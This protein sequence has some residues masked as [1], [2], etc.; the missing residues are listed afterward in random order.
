MLTADIPEEDFGGES[1]ESIVVDSNGVNE[2]GARTPGGGGGGMDDSR[3]ED[4]GGL[5]ETRAEEYDDDGVWMQRE[6]SADVRTGCSR[7]FGLV[8]DSQ[9]FVF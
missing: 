1:E 9:L 8:T 2:W 7:H 3:V 6:R 4:D 5:D